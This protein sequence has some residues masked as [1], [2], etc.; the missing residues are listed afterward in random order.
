MVIDAFDR[1]VLRLYYQIIS[2]PLK[3]ATGDLEC[4]DAKFRHG[5]GGPLT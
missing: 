5:A 1:E 4:A 3:S 2:H